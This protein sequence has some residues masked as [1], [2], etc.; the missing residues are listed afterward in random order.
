MPIF[1]EAPVI[2][3]LN[4]NADKEPL[5]ITALLNKSTRWTID[6]INTENSSQKIL[7]SG[8]G[9]VIDCKWYGINATAQPMLQGLYRVTITAAGMLTPFSRDVWLG[10]ARS[11]RTGSRV[12]VDDF[13]DRDLKPYIGTV[14]TSFLDSHEG[15]NGMSTVTTF[16]VQEQSGIPELLWGYRL[17][18]SNSLGFNP[19]AALEW[20][21]MSGSTGGYSGLDTI[22]VNIGARSPVSV[23]VQLITSDIT[24][25]N[26]FE[27]SLTLGSQVKE[28]RLPIS[29]FKPRWHSNGRLAPS[30]DKLTAIRFQAQGKD[31]TENRLTLRM[32]HMSGTISKSYSEPPAYVPP[33]IAVRTHVRSH[34]ADNTLRNTSSLLNVSVQ[35]SYQGGQAIICTSSGIVLLKKRITDEKS[36]EFSFTG[37]KPGIYLLILMKGN[38]RFTQLVN[39]LR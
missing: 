31:G 38:E 14:W 34:S 22:I 18:G 4:V 36:L 27:D 12:C 1:I 32:F 13:V 19:Y 16:T 25:H 37:F 3:P 21:S 11:L 23:S 10:K 29:A 26:Y 28:Y 7:F 33:P 5:H 2:Q 17:D 24:D 39:Y 35:S 9:T 6:I 20:N 8:K 30:L 15:K